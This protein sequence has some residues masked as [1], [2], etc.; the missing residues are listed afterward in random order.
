MFQEFA[1]GILQVIE[2]PLPIKFLSWRRFE[3]RRLSFI[4]R[5]IGLTLYH[6]AGEQRSIPE[7]PVFHL[8]EDRIDLLG[9]FYGPDSCHPETTGRQG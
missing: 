2:L 1:P 9:W 4:Q 8:F 3:I 6:D 5:I 7:V